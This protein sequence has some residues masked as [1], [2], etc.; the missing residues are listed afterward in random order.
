MKFP[1][2]TVVQ[3]RKVPLEFAA[4]ACSSLRP[5][6]LRPP[7]PLALGFLSRRDRIETFFDSSVFV[8]LFFPP[9]RT[10][11]SLVLLKI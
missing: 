7:C 5:P 1:A 4:V 3:Y 6:S 11:R 10:E 2:I 9:S 8:S